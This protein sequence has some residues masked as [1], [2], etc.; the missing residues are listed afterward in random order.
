METKN[1][2]MTPKMTKRERAN[3]TLAKLC[4]TGH[5]AVN[6][7]HIESICRKI[8]EVDLKGWK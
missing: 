7:G 8:Q 5:P 2:N 3:A 4:F 1:T 6:F